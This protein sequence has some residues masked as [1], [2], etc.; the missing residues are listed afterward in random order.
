[1]GNVQTEKLFTK[2]DMYKLLRNIIITVVMLA[3]IF[4]VSFFLGIKKKEEP[5][6]VEFSAVDRICELA[7]LRCYYHDV[8]EYEKEPDGLFK[9]GLFKYGYKKL[10]MEY[11]GIVEIGIDVNEVQVNQPDENGVVRIYVPEARVIN[12]EADENSMSDPILETGKFTTVT[13][14]EKAK[15]FSAAQA[16]MKENAENDDS[17]LAQSRE[18]AKAL[19]KQYVIRVGEQIGQQYTVEWVND[20]SKDTKQE[21][22]QP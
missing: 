21:E 1:M 20:N 8:A 3:A 12:I 9:Y 2:R 7:T 10:W 13:S 15:A 5:V 6:I 14:E 19:L 11:D 4:A 17:I 18:N 16:T 22:K